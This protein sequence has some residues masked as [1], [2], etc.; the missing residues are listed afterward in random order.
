MKTILPIPNHRLIQMTSLTV[1]LTCLLFVTPA[2]CQENE[3]RKFPSLEVDNLWPE[4]ITIEQPDP[5]FEIQESYLPL[6]KEALKHDEND[7][8][9]ELLANIQAVHQSGFDQSAV[10]DQVRSLIA[11]ENHHT[12]N[13]AIAG[14]LTELNDKASAKKL[15]ELLQPKRIELAQVIEPALAKWN[16]EAI[17]PIWLKR[18]DQQN[19]RPTLLRLAIRGLGE[20]NHN[21][22]AAALKKV[23]MD[24]AAQP[25]IRIEAAKSLGKIS[26]EHADQ[27]KLLASKPGRKNITDR[28]CAVLL[29]SQ[30]DSEAAIKLI[31]RLMTDEEGAVAGIAWERILE[32]DPA[33]AVQLA[34]KCLSHRDSKVRGHV[35]T[36]LLKQPNLKR[37][38][39]LGKLMADQHP[40]VR[41]AARL[42]LV[43]LANQKEKFDKQARVIGMKVVEGAE[44]QGIEQALILL[45]SLDHKPVAGKA[46]ELLNHDHPKVMKASGWALRVLNVEKTYPKMLDRA[47]ELSDILFGR[48][49]A[50]KKKLDDAHLDQLAHLF[51]S[52]GQS[53][54]EPADPLMRKYVPK[55]L[56]LQSNCRPAAIT[57]LGKLNS[58]K[59]DSDLIESLI[60][61]MNDQVSEPPENQNVC[62]TSAI[63][64]GRMNA[65]EALSDMKSLYDGSPVVSGF[66]YAAAWAIRE[67]S[68]EEIAQPVPA[69]IRQSGFNLEPTTARIREFQDSTS[70][71]PESSGDR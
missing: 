59:K 12:L 16:F 23:V 68:G 41:V 31:Q 49:Y 69:I 51:D 39:L 52:F 42:A 47:T 2:N 29:L 20:T 25:A 38:D 63:A 33:L 70:L 62:A 28:L 61:R 45:A 24:T 66:D 65:E 58:N 9:Q 32:L 57:A 46:I 50:R 8:R 10:A 60:R 19:V 18:L 5:V 37:M 34:R 4:D 55:N 36:A 27:A 14:L 54:Y 3:P 1:F 17:K 26:P 11:P 71:D 15:F 30:D 13:M 35:V 22:A 43:A 6:W 21:P 53:L 64:L 44:F 40:Q 7:L 56:S 48:N 67:L